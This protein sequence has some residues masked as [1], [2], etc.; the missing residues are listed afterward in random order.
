MINNL[1]EN[2]NYSFNIVVIGSKYHQYYLY[3]SYQLQNLDLI[4]DCWSD[5]VKKQHII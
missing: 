4:W 5:I 1:Y 3:N 2:S